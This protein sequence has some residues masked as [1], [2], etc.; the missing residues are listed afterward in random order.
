MD[1]L[2][3]AVY[4]TQSRTCALH[5]PQLGNVGTS[6]AMPSHR[7]KVYDCR[8]G[9]SSPDGLYILTFCAALHY[10]LPLSYRT[11][12]ILV[13]C[14]PSSVAC[15]V[16]GRSFLRNPYRLKRKPWSSL[17]HC[18]GV[19]FGRMLGNFRNHTT[20]T[21]GKVSKSSDESRLAYSE[22]WTMR[23]LR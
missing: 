17:Q 3:G 12:T 4:R 9:L 23:W 6:L 20:A 19:V 10:F 7:A 13:G 15:E 11:T 18:R 8:L 21:P 1:M 16:H 22:S 2:P 14:D 5:G